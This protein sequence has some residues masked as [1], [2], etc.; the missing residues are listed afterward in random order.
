MYI[1]YGSTT[2]HSF[3]GQLSGC[4]LKTYKIKQKHTQEETLDLWDLIM[5]DLK[6]WDVRNVCNLVYAFAFIYKFLYN[7]LMMI[8]K[9]TKKSS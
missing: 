1:Y 6:L 2:F 4:Y 3:F 8:Q 7:R 5:N 9:G